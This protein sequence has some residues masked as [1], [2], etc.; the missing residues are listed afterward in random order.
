MYLTNLTDEQWQLLCPV[1]EIARAPKKGVDREAIRFAKSLT[2]FSISP[3]Q[4][5]NGGCYRR[6][7]RLGVQFMDTLGH[8]N[9]LEYGIRH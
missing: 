7:L 1:L 4:V 5:A 9:S 3:R 8:G 6:I 2:A